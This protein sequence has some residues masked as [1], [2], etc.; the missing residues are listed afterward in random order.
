MPED[1][2]IDPAEAKKVLAEENKKKV[3]ACSQEVQEV[4]DKH[5]C[6]LTAGMIISAQGNRPIVEIIPKPEN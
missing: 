4:L 3:D 2:K 5:G 1:K 6:T